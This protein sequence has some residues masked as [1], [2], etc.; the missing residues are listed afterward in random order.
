MGVAIARGVRTPRWDLRYSGGSITGRIAQMVITITYTSH[1][2]AAGNELEIEIEDSDRR[3][4][5]PWLPSRGDLVSLDIGYVGETLA[6]CGDFQVD[7]LEL[8]GPPDVMTMR[9][10]AAFIT[11]ALRTANTL[12]FENTTLLHIADTIAAKHGLSVIGAPEAI[13]VSFKRVTQNRESDLAFLRRIA[14]QHNYDFNIAGNVLRFYS[15]TT[16]EQA[17][18]VA[19]LRRRDLESVNLKARTYQTYRA[20]EARYLDPTTKQLIVQRVDADPPVVTGDTLKIQDRC[21]NGQMALAKARAALHEMNRLQV[22]GS[23]TMQGNVAIAGGGNITLTEFGAFNGKY[24]IE[25]ARH[26][27]ERAGG[28]KTEAEVRNVP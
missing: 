27:L 8:K 3:W 4:Q 14:I 13:N 18:E 10:L 15:R 16:L 22:T 25:S 26:R 20:A 17:P 5:G 12:G 23:I 2:G 6:P 21:E 11:P 9:C 19:S 24:H 28:Y 1:A 7:E